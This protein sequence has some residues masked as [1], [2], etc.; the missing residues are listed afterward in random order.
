[1]E[2]SKTE[3]F[4][5]WRRKIQKEKLKEMNKTWKKWVEENID[6]FFLN[7]YHHMQASKSD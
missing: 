2:A 4:E 5:T 1:M 7:G 6:F 3:W